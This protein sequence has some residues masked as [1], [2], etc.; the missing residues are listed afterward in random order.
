[1]VVDPATLPE[2]LAAAGFSEV[3]VQ[4]RRSLR[5]RARKRR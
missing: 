1:V 3:E 5:F 2:R 4:L